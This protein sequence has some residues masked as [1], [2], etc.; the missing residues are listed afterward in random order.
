VSGDLSV[1]DLTTDGFDGIAIDNAIAASG[2]V[3]MTVHKGR[4]TEGDFDSITA[5]SFAGSA[6]QGV[7]LSGGNAFGTLN[8]SSGG[9]QGFTLNDDAALVIA[10]ALTGTEVT[11]TTNGTDNGISINAKIDASNVSLT[12]AAGISENSANGQIAAS[13]LTGASEGDVTL[14]GANRITNIAAFATNDGDFSL[15]TRGNLTV[16]GAVDTGSGNLSLTTVTSGAISIDSTLETQATMNLT[17]AADVTEDISTGVV[18]AQTLNVI[19][20]TG[21]SLNS[22]DNNITTIGTDTTTTG[23]NNITQ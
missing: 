12:S 13:V 5:A 23:P 19:A 10:G 17:S 2:A 14:N 1:T 9:L 11:I 18:D 7:T 16:I 22:S 20:Q 3:T 15:T 6:Q 21:I 8:V 4:I